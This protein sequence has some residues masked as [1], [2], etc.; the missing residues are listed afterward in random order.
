MEITPTNHVLEEM[1][2]DIRVNIFDPR[3]GQIFGDEEN[4]CLDGFEKPLIM[5]LSLS[6][7]NEWLRLQDD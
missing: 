3:S 2:T 7:H 4:L 5:V 6:W 1:G